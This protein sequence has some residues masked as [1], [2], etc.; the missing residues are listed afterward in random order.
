MGKRRKFKVTNGN[1]MEEKNKKTVKSA[2]KEMG[3]KLSGINIS[4]GYNACVG[5]LGKHRK[6]TI[7]EV[8]EY[9]TNHWG[10]STADFL[11]DLG[12]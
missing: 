3:E 5:T 9:L 1:E 8:V 11:E 7:K 12:I 4:A 10:G 2:L 6:W